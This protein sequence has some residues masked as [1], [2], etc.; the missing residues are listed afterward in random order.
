MT[1]RLWRFFWSPS[2]VLSL[3]TLL[4]AGS[5]GG[6]LFWG[7]LH[8]TI[9]LTNGESFCIGCHEMRDT[10]YVEYQQSVHCRNASGV[11]AICS[12]CHVP[13]SWLPKMIR[14]VRAPNELPHHLLGNIDTPG[15]VR[16]EPRRNGA[17]RMGN[18]E[19]QRFA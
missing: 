5:L 15:I 8:W 3:G 12:V 10:V 17:T 19:G 9:E 13:K 7:G 11:G 1:R 2:G 18:D 14:K 16:G 6:I 4:I